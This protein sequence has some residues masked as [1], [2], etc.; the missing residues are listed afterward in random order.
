MCFVLE[1]KIGLEARVIKS[2][3]SL[4]RELSIPCGSDVLFFHELYKKSWELFSDRCF[5]TNF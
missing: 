2:W 3:L 4:F 1:Y 5:D